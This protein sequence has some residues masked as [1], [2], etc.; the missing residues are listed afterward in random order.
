MTMMSLD[1]ISEKYYDYVIAYGDCL[2]QRLTVKKVVATL[3]LLD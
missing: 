3:S 2:T 1:Q